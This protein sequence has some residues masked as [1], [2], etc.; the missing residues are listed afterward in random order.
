MKQQKLKIACLALFL[1]ILLPGLAGAAKSAWVTLTSSEGGFSISMPGK[2]KLTTGVHKSFVGS[3]AENTFSV[4]TANGNYSIEYSNLPGIAVSMGGEKTIYNKTK[5]N[6][7]KVLGG[8]EISFSPTSFSGHSGMEL[9]FIIPSYN[10]SGTAR[11]YLVEKRLYV[12]VA[13]N[14]KSPDPN[15]SKFFGSFQIQ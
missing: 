4:K 14:K 15:A 9:T 8:Q 13:S 12:L 5:E 6:L 1:T 3:I 2:A 7:L 10:I 11:F